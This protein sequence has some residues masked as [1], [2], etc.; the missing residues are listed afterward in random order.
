[1]RHPTYSPPRL[2]SLWSPGVMPNFTYG[3]PRRL[4]TPRVEAS[5]ANTPTPH[6]R[7][8]S[9]RV[10]NPEGGIHRASVRDAPSGILWKNK[11]RRRNRQPRR[12]H[13]PSLSTR[14]PIQGSMKEQG[15]ATEQ[16]TQKAAY[17]EPQY[18]TPHPGFY[19][20]TRTGDGTGNPEGN[21]HRASVR[22]AP[23]RIAACLAPFSLA[24]GSASP[25][26]L[27]TPSASH[28]HRHAHHRCA[29]NAAY[30]R[31]TTAC[32]VVVAGIMRIHTLHPHLPQS[33]V[34]LTVLCSFSQHLSRT[35]RWLWHVLGISY[36]FSYSN[37]TT[38]HLERWTHVRM[39]IPPELQPHTTPA[40]RA[41]NWGGT[42][43]RRAHLLRR[44][45][46][47]QP[48]SRNVPIDF[49]AW[50]LHLLDSVKMPAN[51]TSIARGTHTVCI[52][53]LSQ[54]CALV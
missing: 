7:P 41:P 19:E 17:T 28:L 18:E 51:Q 47:S 54:H 30:L 36:V 12:R 4:L 50:D 14:R 29:A 42:A 48:R 22:D 13:T 33:R 25:L 52:S 40:Q 26:L 15:P 21:L 1:L 6:V 38:S 11:D 44:P 37:C 45:T 3:M 32:L 9:T 39:L 24:H 5:V 35:L 46:Y 49:D 31:F 10:P 34:Q 8:L 16:A 53:V 43:R 2:W 23:S 27:R 20:R